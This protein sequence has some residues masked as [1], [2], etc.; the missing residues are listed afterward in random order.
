[1]NPLFKKTEKVSVFT[2]PTA[3]VVW[4]EIL[5]CGIDPF[6]PYFGTYFLSSF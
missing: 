3:T 4:K 2:E 5:N 1:M 6:K